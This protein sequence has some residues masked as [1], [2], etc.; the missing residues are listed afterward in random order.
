[1]SLN[2]NLWNSGYI[3]GERDRIFINTSLG[4]LASCSYCYLPVLGY[5]NGREPDVYIS[6]DKIIEEVICR[7]DFVKGKHGSI[8]SIGCFSECWSEKNKENI[9]NIIRYFIS[10]GNPV[11]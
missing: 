8:I 11:Q 2:T 10:Q 7:S 9:K 4:C 5:I 1:M 3:S 6:A